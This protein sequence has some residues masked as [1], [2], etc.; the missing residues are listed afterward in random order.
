MDCF[1]FW[2]IFIKQDKWLIGENKMGNI[3]YQNKKKSFWMCIN[4]Q[5]SNSLESLVFIIWFS[6]ICLWDS[7]D[8][9]EN[10]ILSKWKISYT[11]L[12]ELTFLETHKLLWCSYPG[13]GRTE[14]AYVTISNKILSSEFSVQKNNS[15]LFSFFID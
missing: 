14:W 13:K 7:F 15:F 11:L 3:Y 10:T 9:S 12:F 1:N 2:N 4:I 6:L 8:I 5:H